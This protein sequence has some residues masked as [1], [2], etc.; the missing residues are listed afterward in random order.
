MLDALKPLIDSGV[1]TE[2][3]QRAISEAWNSQL[4][5]ARQQLQIQLREEFA[6]RYQHDREAMVEA[7]DRMVTDA[8]NEEIQE[9]HQDQRNIKQQRV[10]ESRKMTQISEQFQRFLT[11]QLAQELTEFRADR[12]RMKSAAKVMENFVAENL[13]KEIKEFHQDKKRVVE[14]RVRL[15]AEARGQLNALKAKFIKRSSQA[16]EKLV[17]AK[18]RSE[19]TQLREDINRAKQNNFGRKI[20]EAFASEF[21]NSQ[22]NE[23]Q[24]IRKLNHKLTESRK[25]ITKRQQLIESQQ[26]KLRQLSEGQERSQIMSELLTPLN[27]ENQKVMR[28]LLESVQT[29]QLRKAYDKYLPA[30]VNPNAAVPNKEK[31]ALVESRSVTGNRTPVAEPDNII[32]IKRLAGL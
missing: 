6:Q 14:T 22:M 17:E 20:F 8:L 16:V 26:R 9:F 13:A 12:K 18:L 5:E 21:T 30:L 3:S 32:E 1:L 4:Q 10:N 11:K 19:L 23:S 28:D 29:S 24:E 27:R 31:R 15:V 7:L 2:D 25:Q